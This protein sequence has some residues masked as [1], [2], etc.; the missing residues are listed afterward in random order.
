M[1]D[2]GYIAGEEIGE[3]DLVYIAADNKLYKVT[4]SMIANELNTYRARLL[5]GDIAI[6]IMAVKGLKKEQVLRVPE[7]LKI[8]IVEEDML[9]PIKIYEMVFIIDPSTVTN[10]GADYRFQFIREHKQGG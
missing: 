10:I 5:F 6:W 4:P 1:T 8:G 3:G 2:N 7:D 9:L